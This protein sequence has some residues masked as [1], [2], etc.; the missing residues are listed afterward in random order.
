MKSGSLAFCRTP[1]SQWRLRQL[2]NWSRRG[3]AGEGG[4]GW[5]S[6][7]RH[8]G[9]DLHPFEPLIEH[10]FRRCTAPLTS[11]RGKRGGALTWCRHLVDLQ[12]LWLHGRGGDSGV[13]WE[14]EKYTGILYGRQDPG[15]A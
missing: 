12:L 7:S 13:A 5:S 4:Y 14:A 8:R 6:C 10:T 3:G 11:L 9:V 1:C 2:Q 15:R